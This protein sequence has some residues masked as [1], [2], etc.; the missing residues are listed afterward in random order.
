MKAAT[1]NPRW[2]QWKQIVD[3]IDPPE[4]PRRPYPPPP[5]PAPK[6]RSN[7]QAIVP[8]NSYTPTTATTECNSG[9]TS[10]WTSKKNADKQQLQRYRPVVTTPPY[11]RPD[12]ANKGGGGGDTSKGK[13]SQKEKLGI[14][15]IKGSI[16]PRDPLAIGRYKSPPLPERE[17]HDDLLVHVTTPSKT[18]QSSEGFMTRRRVYFSPPTDERVYVP[19]S[20]HPP[21]MAKTDRWT[22]VRQ[23]IEQQTKKIASHVTERK[24]S[25]TPPTDTPPKR[26]P[27]NDLALPNRSD[28]VS[29]RTIHRATNHFKDT[30]TQTSIVAVSVSIQTSDWPLQRSIGT[31]TTTDWPFVSLREMVN[32]SSARE[33]WKVSSNNGK[34]LTTKKI[35][36]RK[37]KLIE[38]LQQ[39]KAFRERVNTEL[40][41]LELPE[42]RKSSVRQEV[43]GGVVSPSLEGTN[44]LP[45]MKPSDEQE[46]VKRKGRSLL[47]K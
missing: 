36:D 39:R 47:G 33:Q 13:W 31:Q 2:A 23:A 15:P 46:V 24:K 27:T 38:H 11:D 7:D 30:A 32:A 8:R 9:R 17:L 6:G 14:T 35:S 42:Q 37:S 26:T 19:P 45:L 12:T 16:P 25:I 4:L 29:Q 21:N 3:W 20:T 1:K 41:L 28:I 40:R 34:P 18:D 22:Y 44:R 10:G 43:L 5:S